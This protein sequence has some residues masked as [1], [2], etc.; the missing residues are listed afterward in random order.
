MMRW[1]RLAGAIILLASLSEGLNA[2]GQP[3]SLPATNIAI[4]VIEGTNVAILP[5]GAQ[6]WFEAKTNMDLFV[7]DRIR[8]GERSRVAVR[9]SDQ[10]I[11][12]LGPKSEVQVQ[13]PKGPGSPRFSLGFLAGLLHFFHRDEPTDLEVVS[14]TAS[15]AVRGTEFEMEVAEDGTTI[16]TVMD[17]EVR[18]SNAL[19][20][21]DLRNRQQGI[22]EPGKGPVLRPAIEAI[23]N[24][25]QWT[26][27]YPGILDTEELA[28]NDPERVAL[29]ASLGSYRSGDLLRAL[30]EYPAGRTPQSDAERIYFAGLL[31]FRAF[32]LPFLF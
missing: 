10:S 5:A 31:L 13:P 11:V 9:L 20:T 7:G 16:L 8:V 30:S 25:I 6:R 15:A 2:Q 12:R 21:L 26:L 19:G 22:V 32:F 3:Q 14:R 18:L 1:V 4:V 27:Y 24:I 23:N 28:L 17:G 29:G